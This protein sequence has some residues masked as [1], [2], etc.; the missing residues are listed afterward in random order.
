MT[1]WSISNEESIQYFSR[2]LNLPTGTTVGGV[3]LIL[4]MNQWTGDGEMQNVMF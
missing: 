4:I 1:R 2:E 3:V